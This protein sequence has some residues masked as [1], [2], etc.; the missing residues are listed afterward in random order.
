MA[1]VQ[2]TEAEFLSQ[3]KFWSMVLWRRRKTHI[4][5]QRSIY[6]ENS[7]CGGGAEIVS[8]HLGSSNQPFVYR[9]IQNLYVP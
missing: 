1:I 5:G 8:C 2:T 4:S 7:G 9:G 6:P 3:L